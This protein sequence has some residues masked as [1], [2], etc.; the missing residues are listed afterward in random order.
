MKNKK[1][2][3]RRILYDTAFLSIALYLIQEDFMKFVEPYR[4]VL[5]IGFAISART[6]DYLL[7]GW[8]RDHT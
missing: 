2:L 7:S 5:M 8:I 1:I 6:V 4:S 3:Y